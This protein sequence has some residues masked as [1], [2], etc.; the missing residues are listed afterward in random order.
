MLY[1]TNTSPDD[2][3]DLAGARLNTGARLRVW[4]K[5]SLYA[6]IALLFSFA[7]VHPFLEGHALHAYW[8]SLGKYLIIVAMICFVPF[9]YC[10]LLLWGAWTSMRDLR[11]R[12]SG[13]L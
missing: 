7:L 5:R 9:V 3:E 4:R 1:D 6:A 13:P 11:N 2:A 10:L 12:E 8:D